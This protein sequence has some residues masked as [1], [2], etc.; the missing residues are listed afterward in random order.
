MRP[1][2]LISALYGEVRGYHRL[3]IRRLVAANEG[4]PRAILAIRSD[5]LFQEHVHRCIGRF[6]LYAERVKAHRGSLPRSGQLVRPEEL[7]IWTRRDQIDFFASEER[8]A[9]GHYIHETGGSTGLV[10]RLHVTRES[11]EWRT[12]IADRAYGWAGAEE[13][14]HSLHIWGATRSANRLHGYKVFIHR[15]LQ[16]RTYFNAFRQFTDDERAACCDVIN[17]MKPDAIV[18]YTGILVDI[19]RFAREHNALRWKAPTL[20]STAETLQCGQREL[21]IGQLADDVFD[22]YG[23]REFMNIATECSQHDGYHIASDN[24]RV[25]V[26]DRD[27]RPVEAGVEGRIVVTD[28]H[29]AATPFVRYEVGDNGVMA[30]SDRPC[31][32][33]RPFP[34]LQSVEGRSQDIIHTHHGWVSAINLQDVLEYFDW[35]EGYQLLQPSPDRLIIKLLTRV[36]LTE[37]RLL[38]LRSRLHTQLGD[39]AVTFERVNELSRRPNGKIELVTRALDVA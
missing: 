36:E 22:S 18:G 15:V 25:E 11:Y 28:F 14:T 32:C 26:V 33:G 21:L 24:L 5:R 13:G 6:P 8:P 35:V 7:P 17:R 38:P 31:R 37:E 9:D 10:V 29:N 12:A 39:L 4:I 2:T 30:P 27:G 23:S 19:A 1:Q 20:I 16:R 34:L 3:S